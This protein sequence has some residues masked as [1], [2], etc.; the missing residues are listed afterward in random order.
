MD[1][2]RKLEILESIALVAWNATEAGEL[3]KSVYSDVFELFF[4]ELHDLTTEGGATA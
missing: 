3:D 4:N 1:N 2:K